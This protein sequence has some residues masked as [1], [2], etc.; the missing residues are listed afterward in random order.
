M[1]IKYIYNLIF[2]KRKKEIDIYIVSYPKSGRTWLRVILGKIISDLYHLTFSVEIFKLTKK[3]KILPTIEFS[4]ISEKYNYL[5]YKNKKIIF[6]VRDPRDV[7]VSSYFHQ[8]KRNKIFNGE[9]SDFLRDEK[10][11]IKSIIKIN[12][13]FLHA[14]DFNKMLLIKYENLKTNPKEE[15]KKVLNFVEI[16]FSNESV[17]DKAIS[18]S[19]F[20]NMQK[21]E[22]ENKFNN[23]RLTPADSNDLESFKV[24]KGMVGGYYN[25]LNKK[26]IEFLDNSIKDMDE[27]FGYFNEAEIA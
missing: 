20:D 4:H 5:K 22:K 26:D 18:F 21:M 7:V 11:G 9:L 16:Q 3:N 6:L 1:N 24:R 23:W 8:V 15:I 12:N 27:G 2:K 25:Y 17:I 14:L 13:T 10:F 19:S